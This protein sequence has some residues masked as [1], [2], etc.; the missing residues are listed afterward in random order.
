MADAG[1]SGERRVRWPLTLAILTAIGVALIAVFL[2]LGLW[3][4]QRRVWK[5][6]LIATVEARLQAPPVAAPHGSG[7]RRLYPRDG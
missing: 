6:N 3:Q 5:L 7:L 2:S 4:L 1:V